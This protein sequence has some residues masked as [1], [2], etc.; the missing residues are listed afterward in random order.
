MATSSTLR[1]RQ[2]S[3]SGA[4]S[5]VA[6]VAERLH[7]TSSGVMVIALVIVGWLLARWMGARTMYLMVYAAVLAILM[8]WF[9]SRR[10]LA[11][12]VE[13]SDLPLRMRADQIVSVE[14]RVKARRRLSTVVLQETLPSSLGSTVHIPV[15]SLGRHEELEHR[16]TFRPARRGIYNVGPLTATWSDP[17]GLTTQRQTLAEPVEIIVHPTTEKVRDR[18]LT[19]MWEDPPVRP[20]VSKP[21]PVGFEFYG[22]RDYVPGDDLRRVVWATVART[23]KMMVRESEQGI[24]DRVVIFVDTGKEWH[25]PGEVSETFETAIKVAA[26]VGVQHL[27]DG[28]SVTLLTNQG[29]VLVG[30]RGSQAHLPYLDQ[31]AR[32]QLDNS[33]IAD[34]GHILLEEARTR[35]HFLVV[36]P[37]LEAT[38]AQRLKL[39]IDRGVSVAIAKVLWEESDPTSL[40]RAASLGA[41]IV[42]VPAGVSLQAVFAN[43][44]GAGR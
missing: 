32:L 7:L 25:S 41:Q 24:T 9:V 40:A 33:S 23:G 17:F 43:Q 16:Y 2:L 36:T 1:L 4:S 27:D 5:G 30:A 39:I 19:R 34:V 22:M 12:D 14:L 21:W 26:S 13:R 15:A 11:V 38:A 8:A 31:L 6:R 42:Q 28:F 10:R 29:R 44:V 20:P 3:V 37:H 35:P 18:V